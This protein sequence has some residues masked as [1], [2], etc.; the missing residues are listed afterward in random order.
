MAREGLLIRGA[1]ALPLALLPHD[2]IFCVYFIDIIFREWPLSSIV[3]EYSNIRIKV[4]NPHYINL[5]LHDIVYLLAVL[6]VFSLAV[7]AIDFQKHVYSHILSVFRF[8]A[9]DNEWGLLAFYECSPH[10]NAR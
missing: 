6:F 5:F 2:K 1:N 3:T 8:S 9:I 7:Y 10:F 4:F